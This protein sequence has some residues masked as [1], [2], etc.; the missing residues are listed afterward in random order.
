MTPARA[1]VSLV[2]IGLVC[3]CVVVLRAERV[4][5]EVRTQAH[6]A[7]LI[8][9]RR[10]AWTMQIRQARLRRPARIN[11]RVKGMDLEV[12]APSEASRRL[13]LGG[14]PKPVEDGRRHV[15]RVEVRRFNTWR[16]GPA[17]LVG[18]WPCHPDPKR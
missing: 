18:A 11:E 17:P 2:M 8:R 7:E 9:L 12:R 3:L 15:K 16:R 4:R 1:G 6:E 5:L 13:A 10:C 14:M